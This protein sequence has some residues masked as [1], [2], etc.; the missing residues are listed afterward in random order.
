MLLNNASPCGLSSDY[1]SK[2][3]CVAVKDC[4]KDVTGHLSK[5][6]LTHEGIET[7]RNLMLPR[8]GKYLVRC[9]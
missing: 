8:A 9:K 7:E 1:P 3:E 6:E 2:H 4:K 5:L